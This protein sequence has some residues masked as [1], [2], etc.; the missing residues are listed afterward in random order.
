MSLS[1]R[2]TVSKSAVEK[3]LQGN[4]REEWQSTQLVQTGRPLNENV[5][6]L[7]VQEV[8]EPEYSACVQ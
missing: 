4:W 8:V 3:I 1:A 5:S 2:V 6:K 7:L